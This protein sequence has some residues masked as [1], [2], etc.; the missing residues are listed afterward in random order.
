MLQVIG[1]HNCNRCLM[2]KTILKNKGV[3]YDYLQYE[4]LSEVEQ[5]YYFEQARKAGHAQFPIILQDGIVIT[6]QDI[7]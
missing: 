6:L 7:R 3:K 4:D 5:D 1:T 2:T